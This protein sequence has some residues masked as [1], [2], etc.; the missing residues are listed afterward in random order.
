VRQPINVVAPARI[1]TATIVTPSTGQ[2]NAVEKEQP[3]TVAVKDSSGNPIRNRALTLRTSLSSFAN[4]QQTI[5]LTTDASGQVSTA[6]RGIAQ[7]GPITI[8]IRDGADPIAA[9]P[10]LQ[11]V[12]A[13][14]PDI[15]PDNNSVLTLPRPPALGWLNGICTGRIATS[16]PES[17]GEETSD[18]YA[19]SLEAGQTITVDL[20]N[21]PAGTNYDLFL[22]PQI[23]ETQ[24]TGTVASSRRPGNQ[25]E[26]FTFRAPRPER[27]YIRVFAAT[28]AAPGAPDGYT[29]TVRTR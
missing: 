10:V 9:S 29:L 22:Y 26:S 16:G 21:V 1:A 20:T 2:I 12:P 28:K 27:Y 19:V 24:S 7:L 5:P 15:E 25:N 13:A 17:V 8:E 4:G 6:L 14:C 23:A 11:S 18:Y 3:I